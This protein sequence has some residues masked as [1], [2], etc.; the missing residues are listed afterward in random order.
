MNQIISHHE[1]R[2]T[3]RGMLPHGR[4]Q[5]AAPAPRA[6]FSMHSDAAREQL[7]RIATIV[8]IADRISPR[9]IADKT[10]LG[11]AEISRYLKRLCLDGIVH[12]VAKPS[13]VLGAR[14]DAIYAAGPEP[15]D[16]EGD[17]GMHFTHI[18]TSDWQS[19]A[20]ARDVLHVALFGAPQCVAC[21]QV[22]GEE[23]AAE[24]RFRRIS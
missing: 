16:E 21:K 8:K 11:Q 20:H 9:A 7:H 12:L 22:Q 4:K 2:P 1:S 18:V 13:D 6:R 5:A 14:R 3:M 17:A 15:V 10:G 19:G 23:H 24:C